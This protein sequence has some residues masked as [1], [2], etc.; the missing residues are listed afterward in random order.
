[1][2]PTVWRDGTQPHNWG[3][4]GLDTPPVLRDDQGG[5]AGLTAG[6]W[7]VSKVITGRNPE[8]C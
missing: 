8:C 7:E 5:V 1:M 4:A 2:V 6:E 3:I